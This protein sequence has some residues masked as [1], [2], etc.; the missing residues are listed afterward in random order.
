M[1]LIVSVDVL[2]RLPV[3]E[4]ELVGVVLVVRD[5]VLV[6]L[7]VWE[8]VSELVRLAVGDDE[9]VSEAVPEGVLDGVLEGV[10]H[11]CPSLRLLMPG[12]H[13]RPA[14]CSA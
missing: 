7:P 6:R 1:A 13:R 9:D 8:G 3:W 4:G 10:D 12:A 2:V 14:T 5:G 11:D